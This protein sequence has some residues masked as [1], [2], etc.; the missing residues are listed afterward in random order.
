[1]QHFTL[2]YTGIYTQCVAWPMEYVGHY[3][4][5]VIT[6]Y[7]LDQS[8]FRLNQSPFFSFVR[9]SCV[10]RCASVLN[11]SR[12]Q[13]SLLAVSFVELASV[14][15][16]QLKNHVFYTSI[17]AIFVEYV[18]FATGIENESWN[19]FHITNEWNSV[20]I[21]QSLASVVRHQIRVSC[22]VKVQYVG[23]EERVRFSSRNWRNFPLFPFKWNGS[24]ANCFWCW[25]AIT[26]NFINSKW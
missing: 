22:I 19:I 9:S 7:T 15:R 4:A 2:Q 1:M 3:G 24:K 10:V 20:R 11:F 12:S 8:W 23:K 21:H 17:K 13:R 14:I 18:Q 26:V 25:N 5:S 16:F 6:C